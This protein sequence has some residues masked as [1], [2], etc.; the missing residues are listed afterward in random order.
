MKPFVCQFLQADCFNW[1][2][3]RTAEKIGPTN[4]FHQLMCL[5]Y[6][7]QFIYMFIIIND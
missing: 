4:E 1:T 2:W 6:Q 3:D 7:L 5:V